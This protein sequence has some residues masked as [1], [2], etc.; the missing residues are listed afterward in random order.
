MGG[1]QQQ[2]QHSVLGQL[3]QPL[4]WDFQSASANVNLCLGEF[5]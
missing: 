3:R 5:Q 2:Q 1:S 4:P